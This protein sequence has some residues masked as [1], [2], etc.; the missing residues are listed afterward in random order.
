MSA[1]LAWMQ[2]FP[3]V[4][5]SRAVEALRLGWQAMAA[6]EKPGFNPKT[7]EPKLTRVLRAYVR[8]HVAVFVNRQLLRDR[9]ALELPLANG[10][11]V[12][13]VQALSGG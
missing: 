2:A 10:D 6:T 1:G 5:A 7:H 13:V 8:K 9:C 4:E 11:R 3:M 12:L